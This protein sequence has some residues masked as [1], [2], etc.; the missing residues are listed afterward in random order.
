MTLSSSWMGEVKGEN[1]VL[2]HFSENV[3]Y[4]LTF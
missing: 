3:K 2:S 4:I 1:E